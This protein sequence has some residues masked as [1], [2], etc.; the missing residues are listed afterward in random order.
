MVLHLLLALAGAET[1]PAALSPDR[2]SGRASVRVE[3]GVRVEADRLADAPVARVEHR[4]AK[5]EDGTPYELVIL[6]VE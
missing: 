4:K 3:R 1:S 2:A 6:I 5:T